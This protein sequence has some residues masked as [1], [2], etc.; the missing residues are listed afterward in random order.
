MVNMHALMQKAQAMQKKM[1]DLQN[2]L[3]EMEVMGA[4]GGGLVSAVVT[5]KGQVKKLSIDPSLINASE[6]EVLE[7]IIKAALNDARAKA[8][9]KMAEETQK[10]MGDMGLPPGMMG[11]GLP[12]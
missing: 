8:D 11:G 9:A 4:A 1:E 10:A 7:D 6:K 3:G 12:F 2:Q 5:C